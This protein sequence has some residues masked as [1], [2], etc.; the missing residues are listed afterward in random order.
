MFSFDYFYLQVKEFQV[1]KAKKYVEQHD[2]E[3]IVISHFEIIYDN[4]TEVLGTPVD[5]KNFKN[6]RK[7]LGFH[8]SIFYFLLDTLS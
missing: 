1:I 2:K 7:Y 4:I 5:Y 3:R 6:V 8:T